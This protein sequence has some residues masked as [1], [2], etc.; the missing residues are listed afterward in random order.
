MRPWTKRILIGVGV[1]A[2]LGGIA[3]WV[4]GRN[5]S[6]QTTFRT[7]PVAR[8]E[9]LLATISATGTV[10]PEEAI[11]VGTQVNGQILYLGRDRAG[12]PIEEA[13]PPNP[14]AATR[15]ASTLPA[16]KQ[17]KPIDYTS[18]VE[19]GD[20]LAQI[21][22]SVYAAIVLQADGQVLKSEGAVERADADAIQ[23]RAKLV[24]ATQD[25]NRAKNLGPSDALSENQYDAYKAAFDGAGGA[26]KGAEAAIKQ[27][28]GDLMQA[29]AA[30]TRA[31]R[32]LALT[33]ISSPVKG[34]IIDRR[35]N[36]GQTVVSSLN[37]PSLFLIAKDLTRLV[38]WV[39]VNEADIGSVYEGQPVTFTVDAFPGRQFQGTVTRKRL[40]ATLTQNVV[41]YTV[42]ISVENR[43]RKLLPYLTANVQFETG[44]RED[45]LV[46][47]NAALRWLPSAVEQVAPDAREAALA[48]ASGEGSGKGRKSGGNAKGDGAVPATTRSAERREGG[49]ARRGGT[50]WVRDGKFVRPVRVRVGITDGTNTEVSGEGL[51]EG[52]EVVIGESR[53]EQAASGD[54]KNPFMPQFG[55]KG[56]GG[57]GGGKGGRGG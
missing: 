3:G 51:K 21:D 50:V 12:R 33:T 30:L 5:G 27:A 37:A 43:D 1:L 40:N 4:V 16:D 8:V 29:Q 46:V 54:A 57:G 38:L 17:G 10:Q 23:A 45:V 39:A 20:L 24:Q 9:V 36:V 55:R 15:P 35:V 11:D 18:R 2:M 32:D 49:E 56:G 52:S 19:E 7:V 13:V 22:N 14:A 25:W 34:V 26:V 28:K 6:A 42:E 41:T 47:P 53:P 44:R 48:A 31:K